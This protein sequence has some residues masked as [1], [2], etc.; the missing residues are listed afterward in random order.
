MPSNRKCVSVEGEWCSVEG[1][2]VGGPRGT[3]IW[4]VDEGASKI[5]ACQLAY[6]LL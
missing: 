1:V 6:L 5:S 4:C 3:E 2:G